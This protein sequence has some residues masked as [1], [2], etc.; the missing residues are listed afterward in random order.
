MNWTENG[1]CQSDLGGK[2]YGLSNEDTYGIRKWSSI[3]STRFNKYCS[4]C[5]HALICIGENGHVISLVVHG[6]CYVIRVMMH[7]PY[8]HAHTATAVH[9]PQNNTGT[10]WYYMYKQLEEMPESFVTAH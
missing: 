4:L 7:V 3:P 9:V 2:T 10:T 8:I 6:T 5:M 1:L